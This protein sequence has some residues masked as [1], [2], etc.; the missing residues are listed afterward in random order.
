MDNANFQ[1][2]LGMIAANKQTYDSGFRPGTKT[3]ASREF[4]E[5]TRRYNQDFAEEKF[6]DR[7]DF[8]EKRRQFDVGQ[9]NDM[10]LAA[11]EGS[12][13]G[14]GGDV[15]GTYNSLTERMNSYE[16]TF[17]RAVSE[18]YLKAKDESASSKRPR[19]LGETIDYFSQVGPDKFDTI[20][21]ERQ[22]ELMRG[23]IQR[24][25]V[26][27]KN[28]NAVQALLGHRFFADYDP[29]KKKVDVNNRPEYDDTIK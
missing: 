1:K 8:S 26:G 29:E 13:G 23:Y 7:R 28:T 2:Y 5:D 20:P 3:L 6:R 27:A 11:L 12:G 15:G 16:N 9:S 18:Y 4:D 22:Q 21:L 19:P 10:A 24:A 25:S 17:L 14:G